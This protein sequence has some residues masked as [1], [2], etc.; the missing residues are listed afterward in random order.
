MTPC[1]AIRDR[2]PLGHVG[3]W[4]VYAATM[5]VAA[6][7]AAM[8]VLA[9]LSAANIPMTAWP[10]Q[11]AAVLRGEVWRLASYA[12]LNPP[13]LWLAV[14]MYCLFV[15]GREL[16]GYLGRRAFLR[17][18]ALLILA[19]PVALLGLPG[20]AL[21]G[22]GA[23]H[24]AVFMAFAVLYPGVRIFFRFPAK[25]VAL[26]IV[27]LCALQALSV[28]AWS[29][30]AALLAC[31]GTAVAFVW[32]AQGR[33]SFRLPRRRPRL[34]VIPGGAAASASVNVDAILD[35]VARVG[36]ASLT[37]HERERLEQAR[38]RLLQK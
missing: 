36:L 13:S 26:V 20:S 23:A 33:W 38:R 21:V 4:P 9:L 3:R 17:L 5:L 32:H 10:F 37:A 7:V 24:L 15:F 25:G 30:L 11:R 35:K 16:E 22:A 19:A 27:A 1:D 31:A 8:V 6:H 18:Y 12:L 29:A 14:E 28:H 2:A 34:T